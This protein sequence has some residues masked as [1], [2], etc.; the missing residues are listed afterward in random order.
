MTTASY[1]VTGMTCGYCLAKVKE[2]IRALVGL[3]GGSRPRPRLEVPCGGH[4]R[5]RREDR[6]GA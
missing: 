1:A 2:R 4:L 5:A 3:T 6:Q